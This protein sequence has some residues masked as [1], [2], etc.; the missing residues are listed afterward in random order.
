MAVSD[1]FSRDLLT[2]F[3]QH[4]R[5]D[6]PWQADPPNVYHVWLSEIMLQQTQ[7]ATAIP[8]FKRFIAAFPTLHALANADQ[9]QVLNLWSGLGYYARARNLLA[10]AQQIMNH[11][12]G[13]FPNH[14]AALMQLPGIGP[15]TAAA[16]SATVFHERAAILDGNVKRVLAR[17]TCAA[18]PWASPQLDR[19]LWQEAALRLPQ[20][21]KDMPAYTQAMM[22]LGA[23][24]CTARRPQCAACPVQKYCKAYETQQVDFFPRPRIKKSTPVRLAHWC[25][26]MNDQAVW[27]SQQPSPGIWGGL[28]APWV[29]DLNA[30][31]NNWPV[32]A[33]SLVQV[34]DFQHTF[35]HFRLQV[36][37]G[38][39]HFKQPQRSQN[40]QNLTRGAPKN[41]MRFLWT[42]VFNQPLPTPVKKLLLRLCPSETMNGGARRKKKRS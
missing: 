22:D 14:A 32:I 27:L 2:W 42:E 12:G 28:W 29:L 35:T 5:H 31:P 33:Q 36:S 19:L 39:I 24:L 1:N 6:L 23:T 38:V 20:S 7:V 26:L 4:G 16:I 13:Q 37:V 30:M 18:A 25:V 8:Y 3:S 40:L 17:L 11:H 10:C 15:S 21:P 9:H 41:L 34:I